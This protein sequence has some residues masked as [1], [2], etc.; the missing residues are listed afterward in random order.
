MNK[1]QFLPLKGWDSVL[2]ST[3]PD[4]RNQSQFEY[5]RVHT[6]KHQPWS[7]IFYVKVKYSQTILL[8]RGPIVHVSARIYPLSR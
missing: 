5:G 8:R 1:G 7:F 2:L 6:S 4:D 3:W